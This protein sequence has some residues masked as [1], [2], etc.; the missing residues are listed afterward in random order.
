MS[1]RELFA[2][3]D[4]GSNSF[5]MIVARFDNGQ[6]R[7]ID[8]IKDMVRLGGGLD[9]RGQLGPETRERALA[10][11]SRFGQRIAGI[12][13][14]QV[15]AVGTQTFRRLRNPAAFLVIA[16][17]ALGCPIDIVSGREEARLV[18]L[19]VGQGMPAPNGRRLVIDIGGGSTELV[20]G[21]SATEPAQAESFA[22]GCVAVTRSAFPDG[23]LNIKRWQR[24]S[25]VIAADL[26]GHAEIFKRFGWDQAV[27]SSGTIRA[28]A[29]MLASLYPNHRPGVDRQL[30]PELRE[31]ILAAGHIDK[32]DIDGLSERRQPVIAG[33]VLVLEA[34]MNTLSIDHLQV[35]DFALREGLL[36]DLL[37]RLEDRDPRERT[38]LALCERYQVDTDQANRIDDWTRTAFDQVA[39][40][41]NLGP[42]HAD[43]LH[44]I[45]QLHEIGLTIAHENDHLHSGYILEHADMPGFGRQEQQFLACLARLQRQRI[46][47]EELTRLP[48]RLHDPARRLLALLRLGLAMGRARS[49]RITT[50]FGLQAHQDELQL[51]LPPGWLQAH[52]LT[53]Q[54]LEFEQQ[55][56]ARL[57]LNLKL[58]ELDHTLTDA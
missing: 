25:R 6:L 36:H 55:Q 19:G 56:L 47:P 27:G 42:A 16:E 14:H 22:H 49:D 39:E 30:L 44:W 4:L 24:A 54:D 43:M 21:A 35:S 23:R 38:V 3:V 41:W 7:V 11:L 58:A 17:T 51:A 48:A 45:S 26:Q 32:I 15:R 28:V 5:H 1:E 20:A 29:S 53:R 18:Y 13:D 40:D 31:R 33:G 37:G 12:P 2:A 34:V 8:R 9:Q 10:S 46:Q 57:K 52:P 50:D